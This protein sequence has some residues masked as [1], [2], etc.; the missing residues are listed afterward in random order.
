MTTFIPSLTLPAAVFANP[1][2]SILLPIA[3]GT[4]VGFSVRSTYYLLPP[5]KQ[6]ILQCWLPF[7]GMFFELDSH[8]FLSNSSPSHLHLLTKTSLQP[9]KQ[10]KPTSPS[11][12]HPSV[13]R[14]GFLALHGLSSTALW[15]TLP[16]AH[17]MYYLPSPPSFP[18][19]MP[20][21]SK[22]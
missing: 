13:L 17:S 8:P 9:K 6:Y 21:N 14:H 19:L 11:N 18:R 15:D 3:L 20:I 2:A 10:R 16:T 4:A 1:A 7:Y 5:I 12:N 22:C